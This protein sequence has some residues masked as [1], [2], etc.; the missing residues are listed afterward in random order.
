LMPFPDLL[1]YKRGSGSENDDLKHA[2]GAAVARELMAASK[3]YAALSLDR[4]LTGEH[5]NTLKRNAATFTAEQDG[6]NAALSA[7][8]TMK[9][10]YSMRPPLDRDIAG[11]AEHVLKM[12][13]AKDLGKIADYTDLLKYIFPEQETA[14]EAGE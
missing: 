13:I 8:R 10:P 11:K 14:E 2:E 4:H 7:L 9:K 1:L 3:L 6:T 12:L 5:L